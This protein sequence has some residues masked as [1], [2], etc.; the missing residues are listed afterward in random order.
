M[1]GIYSVKVGYRL[2]VEEEMSSNVG[3]SNVSQSK[4]TWNG[5]WKMRTPNRTKTL[6]WHANL[7]ALPTRV[8]LVKRKVL[9][10]PTCQ[11]EASE[12]STFLE[13]FRM[14]ME[15]SHPT[16]LFAMLAYQIWFKRNKL[17]MG[18]EVADLKLINSM[19][20]D[21]LQEFQQA[22]TTPPKPPPTRSPTKWMPPP[23]EWVKANFVNAIKFNEYSSVLVSASY[24]Q[25][26]RAWDCRSHS[27][28]S[29]QIIDSFSDSVMYVC[30]KKSGSIGGSVDGTVRTFDIRIGREISDD[31]G[32]PVN[33]ISMSN[34]GNCILA[35]CLDSTL[36][37]LDRTSGEQLQEY[38]GHNSKSY[39]LDCCLTNTDAHVTSGSEDG[40]IYFWGSGR[41][42]CGVK[43]PCSSF[44]A[45]SSVVTSV[46]YHP[47]DNCMITASV[48]GTIRVWK[49]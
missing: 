16:D 41:C 34:D 38:K 1:D 36:H 7:D 19:A 12:C 17:R 47:K 11:S 43:F 13:V 48:D 10:N 29:I 35:S 31:L 30:L 22:N 14:C 20:I 42:I 44:R 21:A 32:Q 6:M 4:S 37:L 3:S 8:N 18:E 2:L 9:T 39:K 5:L 27:T 28:E 46:S 26:F 24:D 25:S 23:A 40:F 33:C 45:H 49:T 15:K